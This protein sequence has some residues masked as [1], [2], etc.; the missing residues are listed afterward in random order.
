VVPGSQG[1]TGAIVFP[2]FVLAFLFIVRYITRLVISKKEKRSESLLYK[3]FVR[4]EEKFVGFIDRFKG[5][6]YDPISF[7]TGVISCY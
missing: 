4:N 1:V 3:I 5:I 6:T 2:V 7:G